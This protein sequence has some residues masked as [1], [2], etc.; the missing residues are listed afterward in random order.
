M[1][2]GEFRNFGL[3]FF[4]LKNNSFIF[5]SFSLCQSFSPNY[6]NE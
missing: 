6:T 4:I 3:A 2:K 5:T 1:N